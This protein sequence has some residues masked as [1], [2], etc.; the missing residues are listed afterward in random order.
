MTITAPAVHNR[1][2]NRNSTRYP[3][4]VHFHRLWLHLFRNVGNTLTFQ[5][6]FT[7]GLCD[8]RFSGVPVRRSSL[9]VLFAL[10]LTGAFTAACDN[11]TGGNGGSTT[12]PDVIDLDGVDLQD[13]DVKALDIDVAGL[14]ID[15]AGLDI[16]V[17]KPDVETDATADAQTDAAVDSDAPAPDAADVAAPDVQPSDAQSSDT[18]V[19]DAAAPDATSPDVVDPDAGVDAEADVAVVDAQDDG[20]TMTDAGEAPDGVQDVDLDVLIDDAATDDVAADAADADDVAA[21]DVAIEDVALDVDAG[22]PTCLASSDPNVCDDG[23]TCT[24][25]YCDM[26][27]GC[28]NSPDSSLKCDDGNACTYGEYCDGL[29]CAVPGNQPICDDGVFCTNDSCDPVTGKCVYTPSTGPCDDSDVCTK[30]DTCGGGVCVGVPETC[31]QAPIALGTNPSCGAIAHC[32]L[33]GGCVKNGPIW[34]QPMSPSSGWKVEGEWQLGGAT[35]SS[36]QTLGWPDPDTD[37]DGDGWLAGTG[38][39]KNISTDVHDWYYITSPTIDL[40][41]YQNSSYLTGADIDHQLV[42]N[43]VL[44]ANIEKLNVKLEMSGDGIVWSTT[45]SAVN[46]LTW[47]TWFHA[48][49]LPGAQMVP[50][51]I[52]SNKFRFRIGYRV[53]DLTDPATVLSGISFDAPSIWL[54]KCAP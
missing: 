45:W 11:T 7:V 39:G 6:N 1:P 35:P 17:S 15:I 23:N 25:D 52:L 26:D 38:I 34:E 29:N 12:L 21:D 47:N 14:D 16:D 13:I 9:T 5:V 46:N 41:A 10:S 54:G 30:N 44:W 37:Y 42:L 2:T 31:G 28:V 3:V 27:L 48:Y 51:E 4:A 22:P 50:K 32:D 8:L 49:E 33:N 20:Q 24:L 53:T 19:D 36:G 40:S 18:Q 43:F